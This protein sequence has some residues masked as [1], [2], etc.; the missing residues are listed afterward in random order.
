M[1]N[2]FVSY[3]LY[4][5]KLYLNPAKVS[6]TTNLIEGFCDQVRKYNKTKSLTSQNT[7]F[8]LI[9]YDMK[10]TIDVVSRKLQIRH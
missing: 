4:T 5:K 6:Y 10:E 7:L 9:F 1:N 2:K 3:V 8:N